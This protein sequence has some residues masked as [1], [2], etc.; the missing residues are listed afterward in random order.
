MWTEI[1]VRLINMTCHLFLLSVI[2]PLFFFS[3]AATSE[4]TKHDENIS[5]MSAKLESLLCQAER[6]LNSIQL[7]EWLHQKQDFVQQTINQS[8]LIQANRAKENRKQYNQKLVVQSGIFVLVILI[9]LLIMA[10]IAHYYHIQI[11]WKTVLTDN[12]FILTGIAVFEFY[13]YYRI[14]ANYKTST[15]E[16][17]L[18]HYVQTLWKNVQNFSQGITC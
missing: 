3:Y 8:L 4:V 12:L 10:L 14:A 11:P 1:F 16:E 15:N 18:F 13:F 7:R 6:H 5:K 9:V 17:D 2:E